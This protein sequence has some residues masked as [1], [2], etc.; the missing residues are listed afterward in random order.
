MKTPSLI[1]ILALAAISV[2]TALLFAQQKPAT[3]DSSE[4]AIRNAVLETNA[5]MAKA[6]NSLDVEAF[7]SFILETEKGSIVQN[8]TV[9][10]SRQEAKEAVK[11]G[12][13][14]VEKMDRQFINPQV[15]V[16]SSEVAVLTSEG[17]LAAML[18][19]GRTV[20]GRF[21][22]SLIFVRKEGDWKLLHGHYS[23]P[24]RM[25]SNQFHGTVRE[26]IHKQI[27]QP[28]D[29]QLAAIKLAH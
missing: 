19:D 21:A 6:A 28:T 22:V 17:T 11:Q 23:V 16:I 24:A 7:F 5:R 18:T 10:K 3:T 2:A 14:G 26:R 20:E 25:W 29:S 9:F 1:S 15:T 13:M 12:F 27:E 8:G 4:Q